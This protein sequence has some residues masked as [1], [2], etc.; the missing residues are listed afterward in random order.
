MYLGRLSGIPLHVHST[1]IALFAAFLGWCTYQF[2]LRGIPAGFLL[3]G[4][5]FVAVVLHE[6]GHA[7]AARS[8]GIGT[9]HITLYPFGGAAALERE[10]RTAHEE[11]VIAGAGPAVNGVLFLAA[12]LLWGLSGL[13]P[14]LVFSA[15]NLLLMLYNLLPA[16]PMD[17]GRMLRALLARRMG[18]FDASRTAMQV[19]R[20]F[21][22]LF[23][24]LGLYLRSVSSVLTGV[25][26]LGALRMEHQ[27]IAWLWAYERSTAGYTDTH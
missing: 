17:G 8:F 6:L 13:R 4:Q 26:L 25:L 18:W 22:W 19:G 12:G 3:G 1:V 2:G 27:R 9:A 14:L 20:G 23:I 21:A 11:L 16:Y 10:A 5:I 24:V 15:L 7:L